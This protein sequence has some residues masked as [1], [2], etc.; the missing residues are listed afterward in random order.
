MIWV[1]VSCTNKISDGSISLYIKNWLISWFDDKE[2]L[3]RADITLERI[4]KWKNRKNFNFP[5]FCYIG[6]EKVEEWKK[7]LCK[8]TNMLLLKNNAQLK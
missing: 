8:F 5:Y 2:L 1:S 4:E 7:K 3:L 6:S